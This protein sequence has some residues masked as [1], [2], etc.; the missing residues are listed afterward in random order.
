[1]CFGLE[2]N[3][4]RPCSSPCVTNWQSEG[5]YT[6]RCSDYLTPESDPSTWTGWLGMMTCGGPRSD[7]KS[8]Y[9]SLAQKYWLHKYAGAPR[10]T[11]N[12]VLT[13]TPNRGSNDGNVHRSINAQSNTLCRLGVMG[14][15]TLHLFLHLHISPIRYHSIGSES[16]GGYPCPSAR[17]GTSSV[18]K[19]R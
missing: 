13:S 7:K 14:E 6:G 1:M 3:V 19:S 17:S 12:S 18:F 10:S 9:N 2:S 16:P 8:K 11:M 4:S 15:H 5:S